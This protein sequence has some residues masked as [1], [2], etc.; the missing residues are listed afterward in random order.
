V[1]EDGLGNLQNK[2]QQYR[3]QQGK[4]SWIGGGTGSKQII[5]NIDN[6]LVGPEG[7]TT[8]KNTLAAFT[9]P[10]IYVALVYLC[11]AFTILSVQQ[12]SDSNKYRFRYSVLRKLGMQ[13]EK[14]ELLVMKQLFWG[15]LCPVLTAV[16]ASAA[17]VLVV[18]EKFRYFSGAQQMTVVYFGI[19]LVTIIGIYLLYFV[20]T[21]QMFCQNIAEKGSVG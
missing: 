18:G 3:Q 10:L 1:E 4:P 9:F 20:M 12:L 5:V 8:T 13:E 21:Y 6:Y 2:L 17:I 15:Y 14:L 11:V 16:L 7:I 19:P